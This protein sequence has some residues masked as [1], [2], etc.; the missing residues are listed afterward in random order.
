M[1]GQVAGRELTTR[2]RDKS[3]VLP[4]VILSLLLA[5]VALIAGNRGSDVRQY[6][7]GVVES[8]SALRTGEV[9]AGIPD[10]RSPTVDVVR[11]L[12]RAD[13]EELLSSKDLA[14]LFDGD[15][16]VVQDDLPESL[17]ALVRGAIDCARSTEIERCAINSEVAA[18]TVLNADARA[19]RVQRNLG[20][21]A[22]VLLYGLLFGFGFLIAGGVVEERTA[23]LPEMLR[24]ASRPGPLLGGKVIG[25]GALGL[26]QLLVVTTV[27]LAAA[28]MAGAL[29]NLGRAVGLASVLAVAYLIGIAL[30]GCALAAAASLVS[31]QEDLQVVTTPVSLALLAAFFVG[32]GELGTHVG[33]AHLLRF[34]PPI[35]PFALVGS[36]AR[37]HLGTP[38]L[39]GAILIS[40]GVAILVALACVRI[41]SGATVRR[42]GRVGVG[43]AWTLGRPSSPRPAPETTA[44]LG[45]Q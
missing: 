37:G 25:I 27:G 45:P 39:V 20:Y 26:L 28:Q 29:P 15:Q 42:S 14:A 12:S 40:I 34:I 3:F 44:T 23:G 10:G 17:G 11:V 31:R 7:V 19:D 35:T 13:G 32:L 18:E 30:Y 16:I 2:F 24:S 36:A 38:A 8:T 33:G 5:G 4:T 21:V 9:L 43:E 1:T 6:K 22:I 41:Y